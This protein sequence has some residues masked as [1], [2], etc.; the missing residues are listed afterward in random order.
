MTDATRARGYWALSL[1]MTAALYAIGFGLI[2]AHEAAHGLTAAMVGGHFP[3]LQIDADGGRSIYMFPMGSPAW[4]EALVLLAGPAAN[5]AISILAMGL[6]AGG[7]KS[8]EWRRLIIFTGGLSA[9]L[10]LFGAGI[11][12]PWWTKYKETGEAIHLLGLSLRHELIIKVILTVVG[13]AFVF[14]FF[15]LLFKDLTD[16]FPASNY[17][18]RFLIVTAAV[19][20][21]MMLVMLLLSIVMLQSGYGEGVI[22]T[23]RHLP[24]VIGLSLIYLLLPFAVRR[25]ATGVESKPLELSK[26]RPAAYVFCAVLVAVLQVSVFGN[27]RVNPR[28]LFLSKPPE[29]QIS[30]CNVS[31]VIGEDQKATVRLM[32]RP[33]PKEHEFLWDRVKG[34]APDEWHYYEMFARQNLPLLLGTEE[35]DLVG[36]FAD[37][38][39][40]FFNGAW[41][42]GARVV[43]ARVD[44]SRSKYFDG[45]KTPHVLQLV[46]FWRNQKI[47]YI[48]CM[49]VRVKGDMNITGVAVEPEGAILPA[50]RNDK[51]VL[52]E[53]RNPE[54]SFVRT[55]IAFH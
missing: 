21:P 5:L 35:L 53:H 33:F 10:L 47:G 34:S 43:E 19:G 4:K 2:L 13:T 23:S 26:A 50:N 31:L 25:T 45:Q 46:D 37:P 39:V 7:V 28:G 40:P 6:V 49:E 36:H 1:K 22:T 54:E 51:G 32:M 8:R 9:L 38:Q 29:V 48:D 42:K 52:W 44:L 3:F 30:S 55:Y 20:F 17:K 15:R 11:I 14:G 27:S 24:H 41:G 12:P 16:F 18:E